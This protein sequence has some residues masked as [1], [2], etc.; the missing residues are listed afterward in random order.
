MRKISKFGKH[1]IFKKP[2]EFMTGEIHLFNVFYT[3]N[4]KGIEAD[5]VI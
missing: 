1:I 3:I 2:D 4:K 5:D